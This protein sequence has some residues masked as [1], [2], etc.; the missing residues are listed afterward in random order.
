MYQWG[1]HQ[2]TQCQLL[3]LRLGCLPLSPAAADLQLHGDVRA[4]ACGLQLMNVTSKNVK[5]FVSKKASARIFM[6]FSLMRFDC[7]SV[8]FLLHF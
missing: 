2:S 6:E 7:V 8:K 3:N 1:W 4:D 5:T